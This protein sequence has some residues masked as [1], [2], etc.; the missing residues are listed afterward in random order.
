[1]ASIVHFSMLNSL[2]QI[3]FFCWPQDYFCGLQAARKQLKAILASA[4]YTFD[5]LYA[6]ILMRA[7]MLLALKFYN[8]VLESIS[9]TRKHTSIDC[10]R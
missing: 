1:M 8:H 9:Y 7:I 10:V 6:R 3:K 2:L 4:R 5:I